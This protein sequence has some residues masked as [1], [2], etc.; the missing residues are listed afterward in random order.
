MF[1][2][3]HGKDYYLAPVYPMLL[4]AGAVAFE[5]RLEGRRRL[6]RAGV[7]EAARWR[8]RSSIAAG[9]LPRP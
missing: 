7:A 6:A 5:E 9:V 2:A 3:L 8:R 1:M 4:A